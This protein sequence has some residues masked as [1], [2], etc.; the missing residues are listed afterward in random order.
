MRC[1]FQVPYLDVR[2]KP[3]PV[4][5]AR[6]VVFKG[7]IVT[8]LCPFLN[9]LVMSKHTNRDINDSENIEC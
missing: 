7:P 8:E 3:G 6:V 4:E 2:L 9:M 1:C 5:D